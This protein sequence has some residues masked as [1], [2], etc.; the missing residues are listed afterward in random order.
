MNKLEFFKLSNKLFTYIFFNVEVGK[1]KWHPENP[2]NSEFFRGKPKNKNPD[3][4]IIQNAL[5]HGWF[6]SQTSYCIV[7]FFMKDMYVSTED[8]VMYFG[9]DICNYITNAI[10]YW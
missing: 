2:N 9:N 6:L 10:M 7:V 5:Q 8:F 4:D 1:E 3:K